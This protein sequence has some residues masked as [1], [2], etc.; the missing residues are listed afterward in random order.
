MRNT[1]KRDYLTFTLTEL[2][3]DPLKF[4]SPLNR[5]E[6]VCVPETSDVVVNLAV[7]LFTVTNPEICV[8]PSKNTTVP[9][10]E[11]GETVAVKVAGEPNFT[12]SSGAVSTKVV[13]AFSTLWTRAA[14]VAL[15]KLVS[16]LY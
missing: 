1:K 15:L 2:E 11:V 10:A 3:E 12:L 8:A 7:P 6:R 14:D 5:A 4:A 16:P 13:C 9:V